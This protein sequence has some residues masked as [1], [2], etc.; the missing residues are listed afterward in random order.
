[1]PDEQAEDREIV[2]LLREIADFLEL[3]D[4]A[5]KPGAYRDA[6]Q[7][8]EALDEP[9]RAYYERDA[10]EEIE[11]IGASIAEK[12][13]DYMETGEMAYHQELKD[14]LPVDIDAIT[15]VDG[16]GV[17]RAKT[18]YRELGV[19]TIGELAVAARTGGVR[20]LIGFDEELEQRIL[21]HVEQD[22]Q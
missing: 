20:D 8:I 14:E 18:L 9:V 7:A 21:D 10:L 6:A 17:K 11:H 4:V 2:R 12:I 19:T 16:I 3:Q 22:A 5:Y 15:A 1:M 13:A